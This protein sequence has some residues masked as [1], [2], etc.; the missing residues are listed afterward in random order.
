MAAQVQL[1]RSVAVLG[2]RNLPGR[3]EDDWLSP[4]FSEMLDTELGTRGDLRMVS[5]EDIARVKRELPPNEGDS[6]AKA[7]LERL[8]ENPGADMV[9]LGSY[10][11]MPG[12][13]ET[14]TARSTRPGYG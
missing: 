2:F 11:P 6:L 10:T 13:N 1:R 8:R 14:D 12:K 9:V 7:T 3:Q 4:V 5:A